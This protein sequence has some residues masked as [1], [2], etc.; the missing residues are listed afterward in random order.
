MFPPRIPQDM[1]TELLREAM[2][3]Y[4]RAGI[5]MIA[6]SIEQGRTL[7]GFYKM[8]REEGRLPVRFGYGYEMFRSP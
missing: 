6:S 2:V 5:T 1:Y 3:S 7:G 4:A 8:L